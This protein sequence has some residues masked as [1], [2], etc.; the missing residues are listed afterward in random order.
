MKH[1]IEPAFTL[2][3]TTPINNYRQTPVLTDT[4]DFVVGG[5][6][7]L[8]GLKLALGAIRVCI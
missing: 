2:D 5:T 8:A 7:R 6:R 3:Y 4:S 1:V